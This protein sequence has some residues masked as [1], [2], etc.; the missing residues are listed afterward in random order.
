MSQKGISILFFLLPALFMGQQAL[1]DSNNVQNPSITNTYSGL[2][3]QDSLANVDTLKTETSIKNSFNTD[4][5]ITSD[6]LEQLPYRDLMD[7]LQINSEVIV[8]DHQLHLRGSRPE[9]VNYL[10]NGMTIGHPNINS[11]NQLLIKEAIERIDIAPGYYSSSY[12][13]GTGGII[14]SRIKTGRES[15]HAFTN[16]RSDNVTEPGES[17]LGTTSFGRTDFV[18]TL[19]GQLFTENIRFFAAQEIVE[20]KE[21]NLRFYQ[22]F[23]YDDLAVYVWGR[24]SFGRDTVDLN[25]QGG[26]SGKNSSRHYL[27]N[28]S[29]LF[30]YEPLM[31]EMSALYLN[32]KSYDNFSPVL[33]MLNPRAGYT[34]QNEIFIKTDVDYTIS[35]SITIGLTLGYWENQ[36]ERYD[37]WFGNDY[38][39][40]YDP[41]ENVNH[42]AYFPNNRPVWWDVLGFPF[43]SPGN[44]TW[45]DYSK[46]QD[47]LFHIKFTSEL[48]WA[49]HRI[50]F[51]GEYNDYNLRKYDLRVSDYLNFQPGIY[52]DP[53]LF[54][55][56]TRM[57]NYGYSVYGDLVDDGQDA[58]QKPVFSAL[59]IED[60]YSNERF[61]IS[62]GIRLE[63][64]TLR[65]LQTSLLAL[66]EIIPETTETRV[67]P[68]L[69]I[70]YAIMEQLRIIG[71]W[72][73]YYQPGNILDEREPYKFN[74]YSSRNIEAGIQ[75]R[76]SPNANLSIRFFDKKYEADNVL[77]FPIL[78]YPE[79]SSGSITGITLQS[80]FKAGSRFFGSLQY[81]FTSAKGEPRLINMTSYYINPIPQKEYPLDFDRTHNGILTLNY[82]F[83]DNDGGIILENS[84]ISLLAYFSS[85]SPYTLSGGRY[86]GPWDS[87]V[88]YIDYPL[89]E[90][91]S[92]NMRAYQNFDL[93][94]SKTIRFAKAPDIRLYI[95][96]T[97]LFNS[98]NELNVF[99]RTG[100]TTDDGYISDTTSPLYESMIAAYGPEYPNFYKDINIKNG[101]AFYD[102]FGLELWNQ[103]RQIMFGLAIEY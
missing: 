79:K 100:T 101:N 52:D 64:Y 24:P 60:N 71:N 84:G 70:S 57:V 40:W 65:P 50:L 44:P 39:L 12:M 59:F 74:F 37:D 16:I 90:I 23:S 98:K 86:N 9:Q 42:G 89:E 7:I 3:N 30:D 92:S 31:I 81:S 97:N 33:E 15:F 18:I 61:S 46:S 94:I 88:N 48:N 51:G 47:Q 8:K 53:E 11:S 25:W 1:P 62:G 43:A 83:G 96:I 41:E 76:L 21:S 27:T 58:P 99:P 49:K 29:L 4:Y 63:F 67:S 87:G 26:I 66:G 55:R 2:I 45:R 13:G 69:N 22:P 77:I 6:Q 36:S 10:V 103:P 54:K 75:T 95:N 78:S 19:D 20:K 5:S 73:L 32:D 17:F 85:G 14:D 56:V 80:D 72:G 102:E 34:K 38:K 82:Y 68:R 93:S 91:N 35:Q 28:A